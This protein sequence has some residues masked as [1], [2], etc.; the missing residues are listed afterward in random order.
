[1]DLLQ[2]AS[3]DKSKASPTPMVTISRLFVHEG[4]PIEDESLFRSIVGALKYVVITR[5]DIAF[6]VNK[7]CQ[8][9]HKPLDAHF[10]AVK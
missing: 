7:L 2:R 5:P 9:M 1:M 8:Y 4:D 6:F 10:K 3:M